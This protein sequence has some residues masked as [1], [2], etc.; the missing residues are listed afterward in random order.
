[1]NPI[2]HKGYL[3]NPTKQLQNLVCHRVGS[4]RLNNSYHSIYGSYL[5]DLILSLILWI[6]RKPTTY[7]SLVASHSIAQ[8]HQHQQNTNKQ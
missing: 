1:M 4:H 2:L 5:R 6:E 8:Y 3:A 7:V